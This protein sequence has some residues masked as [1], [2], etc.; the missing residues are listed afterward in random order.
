MVV[1]AGPVLVRGGRTGGALLRGD[2][3][4]PRDAGFPQEEK[5]KGLFGMK[6]TGLSFIVVLSAFF[7]PWVNGVPHAEDKFTLMAPNGISF[8]E[9]RGYETWDVIAPSYR[10]DNK[11]LR[12]ILGNS[13]MIDSYKSG[14]PGNGKAF[15]DG[16]IVVKIGWAERQSPSFP[17]AYEP[18]ELRRVEFIVKD[19]KRFPQTGGWGYA[20]FVYDAK[21]ATFTPWGKDAS[22]AQECFRCH[23]VVKDRDYIFTGYPQR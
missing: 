21:T 9:I 14:V 5:E 13:A 1:P 11:E 2:R 6:K 18:G 3:C 23:N 16:S 8:S 4:V 17:V 12:I 22:F 15:S 10:T 7:L 19:S 20:R